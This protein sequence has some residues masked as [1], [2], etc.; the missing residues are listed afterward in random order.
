MRALVVYESM[1]GNTRKVALA[2]AEGIATKMTVDTMEVGSAPAVVPPDVSLVVVGAP[3]HAHGLSTA[4]TR[5]DA[6]RRVDGP[7]V[8]NGFG[9]REWLASFRP[10]AGVIAAAFDTR[11]KGS[12]LFTGSAATSAGRLLRKSGLG[13]VEPPRS[14]VLEGVTGPL[15]DRISKDELDAARAWG[16]RLAIE[17]AAST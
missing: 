8:S 7:L 9:L 17:V 11:I 4:R 6:A 14:F 1:F 3:T 15:Q 2:I 5:T 13:R 10:G 16:V 12:T